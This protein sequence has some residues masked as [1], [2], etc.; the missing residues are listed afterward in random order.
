MIRTD[1]QPG[2]IGGTPALLVIDP[3]RDFLEPDGAVFCS[4]TSVGN[5]EEVI[6]N[7]D[8]VV[9]AARAADVP[10]VWSKEL[11]RPDFADSGLERLADP[12]HTVSGTVGAEF[13]PALDVPEDEAD[14]P[15]AEYLVSKRRYNLFFN[16]DLEHLLATYGVDT[17]VLVGVTTDVCVHYTAQGAHERDYLYR[18]VEECTAAVDQEVHEAALRLCSARLPDGVQSIE[19]VIEAFEA[20][21][22]NPVVRRVKE[23]GTVA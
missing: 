11:H 15:P 10:V 4:A 13:V 22:G 20:Y 9:E 19:P 21:E 23:T 14:L 7:I 2:P 5:T 16:T 1:E 18:V 3:Q 12:A 8:R 17:V 6:A